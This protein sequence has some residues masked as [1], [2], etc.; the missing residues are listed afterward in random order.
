MDITSEG[1]ESK[2]CLRQLAMKALIESSWFNRIRDSLNRY[3]L[4]PPSELIE[5]PQSESKWKSAVGV[6]ISR[7]IGKRWRGA[8]AGENTLKYINL[9]KV[10]VGQPHPVCATVRHSVFDS[11]R[12]QVKC[13]PHLHSTE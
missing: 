13:R 6:A 8:Y 9:E 2:M 3:H 12:A 7:Q 10:R 11:R 4:P 1:I 5:I